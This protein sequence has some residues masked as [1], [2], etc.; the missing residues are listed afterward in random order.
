MGG[1]KIHS[2]AE[3]VLEDYA[4][5]PHIQTLVDSGCDRNEIILFVE[6]AF[7]ADDSWKTLVDMDLKAFK[8]SIKE[9]RD[10]AAIIDRLNRTELIYHLSIETRD[11]QF[12]GLHES[13]TLAERLREY[14]SKLDSLRHLFGPDQC[15]KLHAWKASIVARVIEDTKDP[16]DLEVSSLI[17]AALDDPEYSVGAHKQWRF[18]HRALIEDTRK[19]VQD[20]R[21]NRALL[22]APQLR[23]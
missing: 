2:E 16:H 18:R 23:K 8:G 6:L 20:R 10:C 22:S 14:A 5:L 13:P 21:L 17:A 4:V 11:A 19:K 9:I 1:K 7:L 15:L 3:R 12:V